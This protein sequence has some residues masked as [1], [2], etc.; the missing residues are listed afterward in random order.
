MKIINTL[1]D[2]VLDLPKQESDW[3][4]NALDCCLTHEVFTR[5]LEDDAAEKAM[6]SYNFVRAMQAPAM[7]MSMRGIKI[8]KH[9]RNTLISSL[10][11]RISKLETQLNELAYV[12]WK[13]NL[14]P[15]SPKQIK[16]FFYK[17]MRL[18][19][20]MEYNSQKKTREVSTS[21][22]ALTKLAMDYRARPFVAHILRIRDLSKKIG[23]LRTGIDG[24]GRM[25]TSYNVTGTE[26]GRWSSN[27]NAFRT[28]TNL[29]NITNEL[30]EIFI[31]D[32]GMKMAY[33][34]LEQAESRAVAYLAADDSYIKACESG[35]LHTDVARMLWPNCSVEDIKKVPFSGIH[36]RRDLAKRCGH[37][38]NY[39]GKPPTIAKHTGGIPVNIVEEFQQNYFEAFPGIPAWH[40]EI[41]HKLQKDQYIDTPLGRRRYFF[42]RSW[43]DDTLREAIAF[44]PQSLVGELLNLGMLH[45]WRKFD[46]ETSEIQLLAQVHDAILIQY[47]DRGYDYE[48][49][50]FDRIIN[51]LQVPVDVHGREMYIPASVEGVGWNWR[52]YDKDK[53]PDGLKELNSDDRARKRTER[54]LSS[55][56]LL[57]R[58]LH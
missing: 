4:Y 43:S 53:N 1:K 52:K 10:Q 29:Q 14:N 55:T 40:Q 13:D 28:G 42:G 54:V 27:E 58:K 20:V 11:R 26:T 37:G 21:A 9:K 5:L 41:A 48:L 17:H 51:T 50:L 34:D 18:A 25:R 45:V 47:E 24:D 6:I 19:P 12:I 22:T 3:V 49:D 7:A 46:L 15:R 38:T 44:V 8:D 57:D 16:D 35:D 23:T 30:R 56:N 39:Y 31:A 33:I 36:T 2:D 32:K